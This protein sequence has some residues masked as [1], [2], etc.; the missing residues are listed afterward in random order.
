MT[1]QSFIAT[2]EHRRFV[3]FADAVRRQH[4][5]GICYGQAGIGKTLSARRYANWHKAQKLL[6]EWGPREES[7]HQVYAALSRS[8]TVFY[9][10]AVLTTPKQIHADIEHTSTRVSICV[11][12]HLSDIGKGTGPHTRVNK[13]VELLIIDESERLNAT[14]LELLRDRYDRDNVAL[15]LIGMPG[16][17][18]WFSRYPQLYSRVGFAHEY[19]PLEQ[20]E[21]H[22][23]LQRRWHKLG[24]ALDPDDFTDAQAIAAVARITRGNFRLIDRLFIQVERVMK[25]N[26]LN[27]ITDDVIEAARSTL[28]IGIT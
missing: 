16:I 7:D 10:P 15:I 9:T 8:R 20:E 1:T 28:V 18:K 11:D 14:A 12:Q 24:Q 26:E 27:T 19:R 6:E 25:I 21:L 4:T 13:Y 2:K 23:V 3:E 5:I 17:E 22:F